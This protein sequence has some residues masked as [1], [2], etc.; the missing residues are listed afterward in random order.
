MVLVRT[1]LMLLLV[2]AGVSFACF[3]FTGQPRF[4]RFGLAILK[5][6]ILAALGFFAVLIVQ[7][8]A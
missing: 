8:L 3:A 4:K 6:T 5:W 2:A 7:R 1:L